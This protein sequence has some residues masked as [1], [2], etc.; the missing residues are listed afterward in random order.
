MN[1]YYLFVMLAPVAAL[2]TSVVALYAWQRRIVPGAIML[3]LDLL[4][5]T[6][7]LMSSSAELLSQDPKMVVVSAKLSYLF[8]A[9]AP[10]FW[11]G[12]ALQ[13]RGK[14]H[15]LSLPRFLFFWIIPSLTFMFA[16]T[17]ELH[18]LIWE[19]PTVVHVT[20]NLHFLDV[21]SYGSWFWVH[22]LYSYI[23][24]F[25]GAVLIARQHFN[26]AEIY[27]KQSRW[28]IA[29]GVLPLIFNFF[30][31]LK[32]IPGL[33]KDFSSL[34]YAFAGVAFSVGIFR[35]GLLDIMP[36]ARNTIVESMKDAVLVVD[37]ESRLIDINAAARKLL[38]PTQDLLIGQ[39]L[40]QYI[41]EIR[42][43][44]PRDD[45]ASRVR[46]IS[47]TRNGRLRNFEGNLTSLRNHNHKHLGYLITLQDITERKKLNEEVRRLASEDPLTGLYNRRHLLELAEQE[48]SRASRYG[49]PFSLL[50]ID[51]DYFKQIN[52]TYGHLTGDEV[53]VYFAN[54]LKEALRSIDIIGRFGGDEFVVL[55]PETSS[56]TA[57]LTA[58]RLSKTIGKSPCHTQKGDLLFTLSIGVSSD[59]QIKADTDIYD[60]L[61]RADRALYQA[62]S[63]GR[64]QVAAEFEGIQLY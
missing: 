8:I 61:E 12:F 16:Q 49:H 46:E 2:I 17:N 40:E 23:L 9:S 45:Q 1:Q 51:L 47:I 48:I 27:R 14:D 4:A 26:T 55:L 20:K 11:L 63:L 41:P 33:E 21:P 34:A 24:I 62:K 6:G 57:L 60:L 25:T 32:L 42:P 53:L 54:F 39:P 44:L 50:I 58:Q 3:M 28:M 31:I 15:W 30:Y 36:I 56:E 22:V 5:V 43:F 52:D 10:V 29:G 7:W 37:K 19:N 64:N 18:G 59:E 35:H 38:L 13:Y